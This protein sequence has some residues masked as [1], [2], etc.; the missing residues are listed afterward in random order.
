MPTRSWAFVST[1]AE[2]DGLCRVVR[3]AREFAIDTEFVTEDSYEPELCLV[4]IATRDRLALIDAL[5][6]PDLRN[7]WSLLAEL[8]GAV[9]AHAAAAEIGFCASAIGS[10]PTQLFDIQIAAGLAGHGYP[11]S[12]TTLLRRILGRTVRGSETRTDWRRRPLS[13]RQIEYALEDVRYLLEMRDSL[14]AEL[15]RRNR[16]SW[17]EEEFAASCRD[18]GNNDDPESWRRVRAC[19]GLNRRQLAVLRELA[20]WREQQA[21]ER[22]RPM[23]SIVSDDVLRELAVRH[24]SSEHDLLLFRGMNRRNLKRIVPELLGAIERGLAVPDD[25]CPRLPSRPDDSPRVRILT[26]LLTTALA[27]LCADAELTPTLVATTEDLSQIVRGYLSDGKLRPDSPL[28]S[29]WRYELCGHS[30]IELLSGQR[31]L[32]V[33]DT[34]RAVPLAIE[35]ARS[36]GA[37]E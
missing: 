37:N 36:G 15:D 23:R 13:D 4:Q 5:A 21:R 9:V 14:V 6:V 34:S 8:G 16:R 1:P 32:R 27:C 3:E 10:A 12:H 19:S 26:S 2:L 22:N 35:R 11:Q 29:G 25:A 17:A 20:H 18:H 24:P 30:L 7:L 28:A 33:T 31:V